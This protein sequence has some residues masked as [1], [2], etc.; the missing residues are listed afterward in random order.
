MS[1]PVCNQNQ[2]E[3]LLRWLEVALRFAYRSLY[4][5]LFLFGKPIELINLLVYLSIGVGIPEVFPCRSDYWDY[6]I[7]LF[8]F[9]SEW[10][11]IGRLI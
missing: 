5:L 10:D 7:G 1:Y 3:P 8:V 2:T 6:T 9:P 11:T 4:D